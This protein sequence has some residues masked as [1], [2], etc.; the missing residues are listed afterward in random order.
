[1]DSS[2]STKGK[3]KTKAWNQQT[4]DEDVVPNKL[5]ID[6]KDSSK[7][8]P[9]SLKFKTD[10]MTDIIELHKVKFIVKYRE[11]ERMKIQWDDDAKQN[12]CLSLL[13][14]THKDLS[15]SSEPPIKFS[16]HFLSIWSNLVSGR[17]HEPLPRLYLF[18]YTLLLNR[19][20]T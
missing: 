9:C 8:V 3:T 18:I 13:T 17:I 2:K 20:K 14:I 11:Q 15:D 1:M 19:L 6:Y 10:R 5:H 16:R 4:G 12:G 7:T